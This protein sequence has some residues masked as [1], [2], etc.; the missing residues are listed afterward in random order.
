M[1]KQNMIAVSSEFKNFILATCGA[2]PNQPGKTKPH[3]LTQREAAD[4]MMEFIE[5]HRKSV[6]EE[7]DEHGN[8][9]FVEIDLFDLEVK[10]TLALRAATDRANSTANKLAEKE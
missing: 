3:D 5:A 7:T 2:F 4:A 9:S 8:V 6:S 1:N 10:R